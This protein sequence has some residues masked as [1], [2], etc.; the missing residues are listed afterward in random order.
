MH[1]RLAK[2]TKTL[3]SKFF[4]VENRAYVWVVLAA[5]C[6]ERTRKSAGMRWYGENSRGIFKIKALLPK[7]YNFRNLE[8]LV[9]KHSVC[10]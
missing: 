8:I 3:F 4:Q 1:N 9:V 2:Y 6:T 5:D 7:Q 10:N